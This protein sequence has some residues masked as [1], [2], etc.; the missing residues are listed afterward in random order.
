[1]RTYHDI[2]A[3]GLAGLNLEG[4]LRAVVRPLRR[5]QVRRRVAAELG[6][7]NDHLLRDIGIR[8]SDIET[9][10]A[11][12]GREHDEPAARCTA[13]RPVPANDACGCAA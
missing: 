6:R 1:M 4:A 3:V 9:V 13:R 12:A 7:L 8:R 5:H 11:A 2:P 10:A